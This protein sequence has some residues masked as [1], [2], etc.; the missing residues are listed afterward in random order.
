[1]K[2]STKVTFWHFLGCLFIFEHDFYENNVISMPPLLKKV[3][4]TIGGL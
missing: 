1:M 4:L 3:S 2:I